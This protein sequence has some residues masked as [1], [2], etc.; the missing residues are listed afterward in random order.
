VQL[1]DRA[2]GAGFVVIVQMFDAKS[3]PCGNNNG[4]INQQTIDAWARLAP[5]FQNRPRVM[6][7]TCN[8]PTWEPDANGWQLWHDWNHAAITT[9]RKS[10]HSPRPIL[11]QGCHKGMTFAHLPH[12]LKDQSLVY[13]VHPYNF[14][15]LTWNQDFGYLVKDVPVIA[16]E[17]YNKDE[18][19]AVEIVPAF[20][21]Q[22]TKW[23]VG[24]LGWVFDSISS[25]QL[26]I[27]ANYRES[28]D[29]VWSAALPSGPQVKQHFA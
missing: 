26:V 5:M 25:Q 18:K 23:N 10:Y 3:P 29:W 20:L 9:I 6:L 7:E 13:T 11:V 14:A 22:L 2:L 17:W 4:N 16:D 12:R 19:A 8:E 21:N 15:H 28:L 1:V 27:K 24:L